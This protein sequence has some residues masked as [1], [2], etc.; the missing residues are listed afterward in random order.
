MAPYSY[1]DDPAVPEFRDSGPVLVF[2]GDCVMCSH[3]AMFVLKH[4]RKAVCRFAAA[5][6]GLGTALFRHFG[7]NIETY[8]TLLVLHRG[9]AYGKSDAVLEIL[10][11]LG[12]P[13]S[14]GTLFRF[15]P[16]RIRNMLYDYVARNRFRFFGRR[17]V[18]YAP[19]PEDAD[20][21]LS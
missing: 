16:R 3:S 1:R 4:D 2:D 15:V 10:S 13:W 21:F 9:V 6:S 19:L 14:F 11:I 12:A 5:Q 18:C 7:L 17:D 20:R 8:E